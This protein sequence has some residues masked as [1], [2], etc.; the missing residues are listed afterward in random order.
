[1]QHRCCIYVISTCINIWDASI[2]NYRLEII[3]TKWR[4]LGSF[5]QLNKIAAA[6]PQRAMK[7]N[8]SRPLIPSACAANDNRFWAT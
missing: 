4:I 8:M 1:M 7:F 5:H 6:I 2:Q 3:T